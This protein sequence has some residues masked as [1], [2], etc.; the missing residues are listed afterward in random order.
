MSVTADATSLRIDDLFAPRLTPLQRDALRAA[1]ATSLDISVE[2]ILADACRR[3][4][5][6][7]FGADDFRERLAVWVET[8]RADSGLSKFGQAAIYHDMVRFAVARLQFEELV[9]RDPAAGHHAVERPLVVAGLPRSGTTHLLTLLAG[10]TQLRSLPYWEA[11]RPIAE[12]YKV[13]GV[14]SRHALAEAEWRQR[15]ALLPLWKAIHEFSPDHISEDI[16][17]QCLDFSSYYLEWLVDAP[18]WRDYYFSHDQAPRYRYLKKVLGALSWQHGPDRWVIK[19]P[20]HMEQLPAINTV[21]PDATTVI[22]HRDPVASIQSALTGVCYINRMLRKEIE[23]GAF[24]EYWID[25]YERLLRACVR[26]RDVLPVSQ[27]IDIYFHEF[28]ADPLLTLSSIYNK[29][30][31]VL[32]DAAKQRITSVMLQNRRGRHGQLEYDL[33]GQFGVDP[34][35]LR[36]RFGFYFDRFPARV[37]VT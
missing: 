28:M 26:D 24:A 9:R 2:A 33:R 17:L 3:A 27:S 32:S 25:R 4:G 23:I 14:D 18:Q 13:D 19:C 22:T 36:E 30:E 8:V 1:A 16:E 6:N 21:F 35:Q 12:P 11:I 7:D 34:E 31:L 20:Q 15:D 37:E 29:A 5:L 10:D